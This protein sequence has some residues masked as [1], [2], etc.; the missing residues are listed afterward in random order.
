[1][2]LLEDSQLLNGKKEAKAGGKIEKHSFFLST[3]FK[4]WKFYNL[5]KQFKTIHNMGW[6]SAIVMKVFVS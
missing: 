2:K 5:K 1:M 3:I 6:N 4:K